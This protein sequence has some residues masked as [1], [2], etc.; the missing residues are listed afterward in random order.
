MLDKSFSRGN[1]HRRASRAPAF[2]ACIHP[3]KGLAHCHAPQRSPVNATADD[4]PHAERQT[5]LQEPPLVEGE[6]MSV[7]SLSLSRA[8]LLI[9]LAA[10]L[11][12]SPPM[13]YGQDLEAG[14]TVFKKCA[15]CHNAD[16][17]TNKI[18]PT[19]KGVR[20]ARYLASAFR[21]E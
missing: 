9:V 4:D 10:G 2:S 17:D 13:A 8:E 18:G 12:L 7:L 19:L 3:G 20:P 21:R 15:A 11:G 14:K 5:L 1:P 16:S 6:A